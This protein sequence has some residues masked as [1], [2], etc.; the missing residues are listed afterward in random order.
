MDAMIEFFREG[1]VPFFFRPWIALLVDTIS[2]APGAFDRKFTHIGKDDKICDLPWSDAALVAKSH[3]PCRG[4]SRYIDRLLGRE[5]ESSVTSA[6]CSKSWFSFKYCKNSGLSVL[7][8]SCTNMPFSIRCLRPDRL[9][10]V[11]SEFTPLM[12]ICASSQPSNRGQC[13]SRGKYGHP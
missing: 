2:L 12:R 9:W 4:K 7:S 13:P 1:G 10:S 8:C 11:W 5:A 3:A 6:K